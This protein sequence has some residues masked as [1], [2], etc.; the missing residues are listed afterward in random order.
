MGSGLILFLIVGMWLAVLVPMWLKSHDSSTNLSSVDRFSDAMRVLSRRHVSVGDR[1]TLL[2]PPRPQAVLSAG[3]TSLI[4]PAQERAAR[5]EAALAKTVP[6]GPVFADPRV[7]VVTGP[8]VIVDP[9]PRSL[10]ETLRRPSTAAQRRLRT[11]VMLLST[12]VVTLLSGLVGPG[13]LLV[14][15]GLVD[16]AGVA[17]VVH[18]R[19]QALR[20]VGRPIPATSASRAQPSVRREPQAATPVARPAAPMAAPVSPAVGSALTLSVTRPV[21]V[22][23]ARSL[24]ERVAGI[25]DRMPSRPAA[26][27]AFV[28]AQSARYEDERRPVAPAVPS[29]AAQVHG[30]VWSPVPVPVPM[31]VTAPM[32]PARPER[33][34]DLTHPGKWSDALASDDEG[35][36]SFADDHQLDELLGRRRAGGDW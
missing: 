10:A 22:P 14:L 11:L 27:T 25:P 23:A 9:A 6:G 1:R 13:S 30:Q 32:A 31:Y 34:L 19:R 35:L 3:P 18:C 16:A 26:L 15:H 4:S 2:M 12:G 7:A 8:R 33:V 5:I 28:P 21:V 20:R 24:V 36:S 29:S 17:F